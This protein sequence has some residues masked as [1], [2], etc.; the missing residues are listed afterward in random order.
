M[1]K[2]H[3]HRNCTCTL[4]SMLCW[5]CRLL[6]NWSRLIENCINLQH[7]LLQ[8]ILFHSGLALTIYKTG[9][10]S[11]T[12]EDCHHITTRQIF[13]LLWLWFQPNDFLKWVFWFFLPVSIATKV[14]PQSLVIL[15]LKIA[16]QPPAFDNTA[17]SGIQNICYI[18]SLHSF[19]N[20]S[21]S[22][23]AFSITLQ[24]CIQVYVSCIQLL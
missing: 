20:K 2:I 4:Q 8:N 13:C 14:S 16:N 12:R 23:R 15:R 22:V 9:H 10:L 17:P 18:Q 3:C 7:Y 24:L 6:E 1:A 5:T 19:H 11:K 21:M